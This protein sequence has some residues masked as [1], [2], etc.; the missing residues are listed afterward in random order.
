[1]FDFVAIAS[2]LSLVGLVYSPVLLVSGFGGRQK[3]D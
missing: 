3:E 1:M 2:L